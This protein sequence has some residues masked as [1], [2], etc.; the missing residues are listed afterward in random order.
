LEITDDVLPKISYEAKAWSVYT[1]LT[2]SKSTGLSRYIAR[3]Y[4]DGRPE[5]IVYP[6]KCTIGSAATIDE[7][8][9]AAPIATACDD[10][11]IWLGISELARKA[12][13]LLAGGP[14]NCVWAAH[15][16]PRLRCDRDPRHF[17]VKMGNHRAAYN[18]TQLPK[19]ARALRDN[20]K[21][22]RHSPTPLP[23]DDAALVA[24][25][26]ASIMG[27]FAVLNAM[28]RRMWKTPEAAAVAA[29]DDGA[30]RRRLQR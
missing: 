9:S 6:C 14:Q 24:D 15:V 28:T 22:P 13:G 7:K 25:I 26:D 8:K 11:D 12:G 4:M 20:E 16:L 21:Y 18:R 2:D 10:D 5:N 1:I 17:V 3:F 19:L 27:P 23:A 30:K 29:T